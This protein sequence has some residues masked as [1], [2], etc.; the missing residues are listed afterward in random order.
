MPPFDPPLTVAEI[1]SCFSDF[2]NIESIKIGGQGEV[3]RASNASFGEF[4]LKIYSPQSEVRVQREVDTLRILDHPNIIKLIQHDKIMIRGNLCHYTITPFITGKDLQKLVSENDLLSED[5]AKRFLIL[6]SDALIA[7]WFERIVHRDIKP[8]NILKK[9][10][11]TF[12]LIDLGIARHLDMTT[13]TRWGQWLGTR[14]YMSPEQA[15]AQNNL[16]VKSDIFSLGITCFEAF[17]GTH[18]FLQDQNN[19]MQNVSP[20]KAKDLVSCSSRLSDLL[21]QMMQNRAVFRPKPSEII[22]GLR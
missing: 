3:F 20:P 12:I 9:R 13:Y 18:P 10:D 2:N 8:A 14:G 6:M 15:L 19:I 4:A 11:G 5:G 16:T 21:E 22:D 7:I 1:A 17:C